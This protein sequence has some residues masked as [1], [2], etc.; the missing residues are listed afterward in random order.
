M[1][2]EMINLDL[3]QYHILQKYRQEKL[4]N[5]NHNNNQIDLYVIK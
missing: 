5:Q 3:I 2:V 4:I 1:A